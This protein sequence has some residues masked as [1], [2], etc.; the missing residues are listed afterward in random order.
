MFPSSYEILLLEFVDAGNIKTDSVSTVT[1]VRTL[2][3]C[4]L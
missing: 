3:S 2:V 4:F 1:P